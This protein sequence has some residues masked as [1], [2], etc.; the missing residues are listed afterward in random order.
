MS[1]DKPVGANAYNAAIEKIRPV[2]DGLSIFLIRPDEP[3]TGRLPG[4]FVSIGLVG[5]ASDQLIRRPYSLIAI[6]ASPPTDP[7]LLEL[8]II[9]V[10]EGGLTLPLFEQSAGDRLYV[11]PKMLGTYRV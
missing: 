9:R 7:E 2:V 8:L 6:I 1:T 11:R 5:D 4:Y 3:I 10:P